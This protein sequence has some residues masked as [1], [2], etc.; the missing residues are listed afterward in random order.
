MGW[1]L[2]WLVLLSGS[3]CSLFDTGD[4]AHV[5]DLLAV[6]FERLFVDTDDLVDVEQFEQSVGW[7]FGRDFGPAENRKQTLVDFCLF[8]ALLEKLAGW[9]FVQFRVVVLEVVFVGFFMRFG[10]EVL[11]FEAHFVIEG[12]CFIDKI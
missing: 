8:M 2:L 6:L 3:E 9:S 7:G 11:L 1:G 10:K 4:H 12:W 5:L